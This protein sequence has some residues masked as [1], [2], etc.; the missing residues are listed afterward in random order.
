MKFIFTSL[1]CLTS[2]VCWAQTDIESTRSNDTKVLEQIINELQNSQTY[3][4]NYNDH[5][6]LSK[7]LEHID[8]AQQ[9]YNSSSINDPEAIQL[10]ES[11]LAYS[12]CH[13][14][15]HYTY[16]ADR[17]KLTAEQYT[18]LVEKA[19]KIYLDVIDKV[20]TNKHLLQQD[21]F[22]YWEEAMAIATN[23]ISMRIINKE[24]ETTAE[25]L[26]KMINAFEL[27]L[28]Q[29]FTTEKLYALDTYIH[30]L[31]LNGDN[32]KAFQL[33]SKGYGID[34]YHKDFIALVARADYKNWLDNREV[35]IQALLDERVKELRTKFIGQHAANTKSAFLRKGAQEQ[36]L[37]TPKS[38]AQWTILPRNEYVKKYG[39]EIVDK[40]PT[41]SKQKTVVVVYDGDF[42]CD[43]LNLSVIYDNIRNPYKL[44]IDK[45]KNDYSFIYAIK[46][47]L[48]A[49]RSF[50]NIYYLRSTSIYVEGDLYTNQLIIDNAFLYV[51]GNI[52]VDEIFHVPVS[53]LTCNGVECGLDL[54]GRNPYS[55][56]TESQMP[57]IT[58]YFGSLCDNSL[59]D[60]HRA[61]ERIRIIYELFQAGLISPYAASQ[62]D[63][64]GSDSYAKYLYHKTENYETY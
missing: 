5:Q 46:G 41:K 7:C 10:T 58:E 44:S 26:N 61:E 31:F 33:I 29:L 2:M 45:D 48:I 60:Y 6:S 62:L 53:R 36:A 38:N 18:Q 15:S 14:L 19:T 28:S 32:E 49:T 11:I 43:D 50:S 52:H 57:T 9:I 34:P 55:Q 4:Q 39:S 64:K 27:V 3:S 42:V 59:S 17:D 56:E 47:D 24:D 54:A 1:L 23:E 30:I 22:T 51:N 35:N 16:Y 20:T 25:S 8:K 37:K 63:I 40:I 12:Y 13:C 21:I